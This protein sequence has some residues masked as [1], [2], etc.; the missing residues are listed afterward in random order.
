MAEANSLEDEKSHHRHGLR[1]TMPLL[2]HADRAEMNKLY[3]PIVAAEDLDDKGEIDQDEQDEIY[4][5]G[6]DIVEDIREKLITD[7]RRRREE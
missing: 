2:E 7:G 6:L 3:P 5:R 1:P 4:Q